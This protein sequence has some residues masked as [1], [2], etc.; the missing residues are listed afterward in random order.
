MKSNVLIM[1]IAL[2]SWSF[3]AYG[4]NPLMK[5]K[6]SK[7][8]R[9]T[10]IRAA[11]TP[12]TTAGTVASTTTGT[13]GT[14]VIPAAT[15][16]TVSEQSAC[17]SAGREW[18]PGGFMSAGS[19][20]A[21]LVDPRAASF[22][23]AALA[24]CGGNIDRAFSTA[25]ADK[26]CHNAFLSI[27]NNCPVAKKSAEDAFQSFAQTCSESNI[28]SPQECMEEAVTCS[29]ADRDDYTEEADEE[30]G[31]G[32]LFSF[33]GV[34]EKDEPSAEEVRK[35]AVYNLKDYNVEK[36]NLGSLLTAANK[37]MRDL[38][39]E[40]AKDKE[41]I[42][43]KKREM[44]DDFVKMQQEMKEDMSRAQADL[45]QQGMDA[46]QQLMDIDQQQASIRASIID[47][48]GEA[49]LVTGQ[50]AAALALLSDAVIAQ[51]CMAKVQDTINKLRADRGTNSGGMQTALNNANSRRIIVKTTRDTCLTLAMSERATTYNTYKAKLEGL[52]NRAIEASR[53]I[54]TLNQQK[55]S[56]MNNNSQAIQRANQAQAEANQALQAKMQAAQVQMQEFLKQA[57]QT[58]LDSQQSLMEV[59]KRIND[60][61]SEMTAIGPRPR[62]AKT[63]GEAK[64]KFDNFMSLLRGMEQ[65]CGPEAETLRKTLIETNALGTYVPSTSSGTTATPATTT[66]T[67]G[68]Q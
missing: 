51:N 39:R 10:V 56:V 31:F 17:M 46:Q 47:L 58:D 16:P 38:A 33:L 2:T 40:M 67:T 26:E 52:D 12:A 4:A 55:T 64:I 23:P 22:P 14:A 45:S 20:G 13:T 65:T 41:E 68:V 50:R 62:G 49:A 29:V 21:F 34:D 7:S 35:C 24:M 18:K 30:S 11:D 61:D 1:V 8:S 66:G 27:S 37:E 15:T 53:M 9:S 59:Q 19:C 48:R 57:A 63:A 28:G 42:S 25:A 36:R 32:D 6:P 5:S 54:E 3:S 60:L 43:T 44:Q